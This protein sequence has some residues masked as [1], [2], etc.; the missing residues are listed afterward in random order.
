MTV[1]GESDVPALLLLSDGYGA[2][3]LGMDQAAAERESDLAIRAVQHE[4]DLFRPD[5]VALNTADAVLAVCVDS[6]D[7]APAEWSPPTDLCARSD[8]LATAVSVVDSARRSSVAVVLP[9][10]SALAAGLGAAL[11]A[12][13]AESDDWLDLVDTLTDLLVDLADEFAHAGCT[14]VILREDGASGDP[15]VM[16]DGLGGL[17]RWMSHRSLRSL[18][19]LDGSADSWEAPRDV[20]CWVTGV[21]SRGGTAGEQMG[22]RDLPIRSVLDVSE[23]DHRVAIRIGSDAEPEA[24]LAALRRR[25]AATTSEK[26]END[27]R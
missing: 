1:T 24:V 19:L 8:V 13:G 5:V 27:V 9:T 20:E 6:F 26:G 17:R 7:G 10:P 23:S 15:Q 3:L 25:R 14:T 12:P 11:P 4:I 21:L 22:S 16:W 2:Q 18:L